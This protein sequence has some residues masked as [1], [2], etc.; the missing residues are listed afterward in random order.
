MEKNGPI[1]REKSLPGGF[2]EE[3]LMR[4]RRPGEIFKQASWGTLA[5]SACADLQ[6][7]NGAHSQKTK[8]K[9]ETGL[10]KTKN[11]SLGVRT[12]S[13]QVH[14]KVLFCCIFLLLSDYQF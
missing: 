3:G 6:F 7:C 4:K 10:L 12:E 13:S 5:R 9:V 14:M 1:G 8:K 11:H 2:Q